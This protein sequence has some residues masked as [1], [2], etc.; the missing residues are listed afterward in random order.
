MLGMLGTFPVLSPSDGGGG[1]RWGLG[2]RVDITSLDGVRMGG[3]WGRGS[4]L[5]I[6]FSP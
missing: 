4:R 6:T 5:D 1:G 2:S 3:T